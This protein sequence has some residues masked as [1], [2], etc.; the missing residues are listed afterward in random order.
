M[1]DRK[2]ATTESPETLARRSRR[3]HTFLERWAK[4][5]MPDRVTRF[6]TR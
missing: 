2:K 5:H 6:T 1:K 3:I 4:R